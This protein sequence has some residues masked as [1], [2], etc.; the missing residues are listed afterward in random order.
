MPFISLLLTLIAALMADATAPTA[1]YEEIKQ[2]AEARYAEQ[3]FA[4]AHQ[5]YEEA[6]RLSLTKEDR[7]WVEMRL[8]DTAWRSAA[9][10]SDPT[11][12]A[13][14]QAA[15]EDLIRKSGD[16]HDRV[17]AEANESLGDSFTWRG[18][19]G[20]PTRDYFAAPE[21]WGGK[22]DPAPAPKRYSLYPLGIARR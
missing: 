7:R 11:P 6:N 3:S 10:T 13:S 12:A 16:D 18:Y 5:A 15:L 8:A 2:R 19:G 14:A 1:S 20:N 9:T 17:W 4:Q 22:D 21:W